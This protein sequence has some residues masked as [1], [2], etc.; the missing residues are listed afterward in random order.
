MRNA[1]LNVGEDRG[2]G[3]ARAQ[4]ESIIGMVGALNVD[5]ERL[6]EL[7][8]PETLDEDELDEL[9][10]LEDA[11]GDCKSL[12][13]AEQRIYEDPLTVRVRSGW[14]YPGE[15][16]GN[17]PEEFEI[18]LCTGGPAARIIG[19]LDEYNQ[20]ES[21]TL[22]YQD[23]FTSWENYQLDS[24]EEDILLEYCQRFYFGE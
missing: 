9:L 8:S 24:E 7:Q 6:E 5:Y 22:Q 13:D 14:H 21:A 23:W 12:E 3:Q 17:A 4:F 19:A 1:A 18:L 15:E 2:R 16:G 20:P 11:A 10:E